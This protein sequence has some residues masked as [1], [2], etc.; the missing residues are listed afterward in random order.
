MNFI[1]GPMGKDLTEPDINNLAPLSK[2]ESIAITT[3]KSFRRIMLE[4]IT[5]AFNK[6]VADENIK[7]FTGSSN[8]INIQNYKSNIF[9]NPAITETIMNFLTGNKI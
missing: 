1:I 5:F 6:K 2:M 9:N 3:N 4:L 7:S 8:V